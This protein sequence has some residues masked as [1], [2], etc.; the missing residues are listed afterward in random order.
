MSTGIAYSHT[1]N[2]LCERQIRVLKEN[3]RI[4]CK[5]E[6]TRDWVRPPSL[7]SLMMNSQESSATGYSPHELFL[8]R[9]AWFLHAPY[10]EDTH[11]SV[12]E[13]VQEQQT[14]VDRAKAMLQ[15][16]RERQWNKKNKQ[17]VPATY[18][19]G[20]W[21]LVHHSQLPAWPRSTSDDPYT[22]DIYILRALQ[23]SICG[24]TLYHGMVFSPSR[25][26]PGVRCSA[27]EALL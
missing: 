22:F 23:D 26:D 12:G 3:I 18:Q 7:I 4:W 17:R 25:G 24:C 15:R 13:W 2:P 5:T 27:P 6:R 16:V 10:P 14:K 11:S 21:V 19:E 9:P 1:S 8:G 20:D